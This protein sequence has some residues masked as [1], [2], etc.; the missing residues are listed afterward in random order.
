MKK[1]FSAI[2]SILMVASII[3]GCGD[4][5]PA[6]SV[7][8]TMIVSQ[9]IVESPE[10]ELSSEEGDVEDA[11]T[12]LP[13][14]DIVILYTNDTHTYINNESKDDDGNITKLLSFANVRALKNEYTSKG[15]A[16][17]LVDAGDAVQG[18]AFGGMDEGE[19]IIKLMNETG[20]DVATLGNHEFDYGMFRM[21]SLTDKAEFPYISCNF[22]SVADNKPVFE[23][24]KIF[25]AQGVK[26]AFVGVSTPDS[27]TSSTPTYFMDETGDNF[28]YNFYSGADGS[29][30]YKAFQDAVNE[31]S[32]EADYV[33]GL[34]HLGTDLSSKPYRSTDL[35]EHIT[36]I[37]AFID[38][39]SHS[40]IPSEIVKDASG[41]D[42]LLTQTGCYFQAIG[43][44]TI[45]GDGSLSS[46]LITDYD[47]RNSNVDEIAD[48]WINEVNET[49]GEKIALL[50]TPL[51]IMDSNNS[52][53]RLIRRSETN[54]GDFVPDA[55]YYYFN[56]VA[57]EP[58]DIAFNNG[59]GIRANLEVGDLSY[60]SAKTV[61]PFGNVMCVIEATGQEILDALE[62]GS[63]MVGKFNE[64]TGAPAEFGGFIQVAGMQ[65][66]IDTT[67]DSTI[68]VS[69]EGTWQAGPTGN[70]RVCNVKV[71]NK[72]TG[73]YEPLDLA[74]TY[75]VGGINYT[76]RN[77]G[78]GMSMFKDCK[79]VV[80]YVT[81][82]YLSLSEYMKAFKS[83]DGIPTINTAN[84]PLTAYKGYLLDYENPLG[85]GRIKIIVQ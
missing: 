51:Y 31:A 77:Q 65:Y 54:L 63:A 14:G 46:E 55:T 5:K 15:D 16:V 56:E 12:V 60:L 73:E 59:G 27:I 40:S 44:L 17:L 23:P 3:S 85:S 58:I 79:C 21:F 84:S 81:L 30:M 49:L 8:E 42:V 53:I 28:I 75:R 66:D 18:T 29:E 24:Y 72:E 4:T 35:I 11:I 10:V 62:L 33:I 64:E 71:Y 34:G 50:D 37:D 47:K 67:I 20:Y 41:K 61:A 57:K 80:D 74:K 26:V 76:L 2:L 19:S 9:D 83:V 1:T 43:K 78:D 7:S 45:A 69:D 52:D 25:E 39:H 32:K 82:D 48:A 22:Y 38:G 36:G 13:S 70:Y 68:T 6:V